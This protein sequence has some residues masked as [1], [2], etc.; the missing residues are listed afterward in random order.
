MDKKEFLRVNKVNQMPALVQVLAGKL[1]DAAFEA[2][3]KHGFRQGVDQCAIKSE[4]I[5][6]AFYHKGAEDSNHFGSAAFIT[7]ACRVMRRRYRW[8]KI[9]M[10]RLSD[11]VGKELMDMLDPAEAIR[12]L[13]KLGV[14]VEWGDLLEGNWGEMEE[15][16]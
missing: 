9:R 8:G 15:L 1:Y 14:H 13:R 4:E 12:E 6:Q 2:G 3:R 5:H 7:A 16:D 10:N 11:E